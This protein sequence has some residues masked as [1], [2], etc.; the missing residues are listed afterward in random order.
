MID[1]TRMTF[2]QHLGELSQRLKKCLYAF[3]IAFV[4]VSSIPNPFQPFG[5][6]TALFGYNFLLISLLHLA[7]VTYAP[8]VNFYATSLTDPISVFL[9]LSLVFALVFSLPYIFSQIY[10]F[11]APGLYSRERKAV[12]KYIA[13]FTILFATGGLFGLFVIF[14]IVMRI[15]LT[16]FGPF[17]L[18]NL[19]SLNNFVSLLLLIP[20]VTGLAFTFPVYL[21]PLVELKVLSVK[22]LSSARKWVYLLVALAVGIANPD[23]TFISSI[24]I[25]VPIYI[26]F[27]ITV[28]ISKRIESKRNKTAPNVTGST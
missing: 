18:V 5:G 28:F 11:V 14:P 4:V 2:F 3:L 23:P 10:G 25:I 27:E 19:I 1:G 20:V 8:Q 7:E 15:L 24:P 6:T 21:I 13:P 12:R 22:Q 16:F 26:L 17:G 9:N